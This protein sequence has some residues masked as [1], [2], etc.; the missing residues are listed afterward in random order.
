M[1]IIDSEAQEF[2]TCVPTL[3]HN[4]SKHLYRQRDTRIHNSYTDIWIQMFIT[5]IPTVG[6]KSS[7]ENIPTAG[8]NSS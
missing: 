6:H 1:G 4:T 7:S 2:T 8:H 3:G 5:V